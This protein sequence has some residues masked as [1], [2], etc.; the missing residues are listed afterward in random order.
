[1]KTRL[2]IIMTSFILVSLTS[3]S[4]SQYV[5]T[6][7]DPKLQREFMPIE[8]DYQI[9]GGILT[10]M[11]KSERINSVITKINAEQDGQLTITIPKKVVYSLSSTNCED[12]SDL[13]ILTDNEETAHS[14]STHTKKDNIITVG[15]SKGVHTIEFIGTVI[16][17]DPSPAQYCG[18]VM[19]FDSRFLPPKFQLERG[20]NPEYVKC[21]SGLVV[22]H[23][24]ADESPACIKP[25]SM[26]KL[27]QRG[28]AQA[29]RVIDVIVPLGS[30]DPDLKKSYESRTVTIIIGVN[31]TIRWIQQDEVPSTVVSDQ[32]YDGTGFTSPHLLLGDMWSHTFTKPGTYGYHSSPHPWKTGTIIVKEK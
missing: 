10:S 4:Y 18:I 27:V 31:N 23:K 7:E 2:F 3:I 32:L 30:H 19:G 21:N 5:E 25:Q 17:P 14:K 12:N 26:Q 13:I 1:M 9:E 11:C 20:M 24:Y 15:F 29:P 16:L 22:A 28:W 6:C 8:L